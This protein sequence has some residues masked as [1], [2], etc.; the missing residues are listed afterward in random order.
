[1]AW[2]VYVTDQCKEAAKKH[3]VT[4]RVKQFQQEVEQL[5]A[6]SLARF[7]QFPTPYL[8]KK[9]FAVY[10]GR[11]IASRKDLLVDGEEHTVIIFLDYMTRGDDAYEGKSGF[12]HD[13]EGYG[14]KHYNGGDFPEDIL[15][16]YIRT[17][18]EKEPVQEMPRPSNEEL[19]FLYAPLQREDFGGRMIYES[20]EW[21]SAINREEYRGSLR[22][23]SEKIGSSDQK[24]VFVYN[25]CEILQYTFDDLDI[26]FLAGIGTPSKLDE[27]QMEFDQYFND[28]SSV[29][30]L[31]AIAQRSRHAYP[32]LLLADYAL[33]ENIETNNTGNMALSPEEGTLLDDIRKKGDGAYPLFI[34]GRAGSGKSTILQ[35]LFTDYLDFYLRENL[36]RADINPP[37]YLTCNDRLLEKA[38]ESVQQFLLCS[39]TQT[40]DKPYTKAGLNSNPEFV[41]AF[42]PFYVYLKK[43]IPKSEQHLFSPGNHIKYSDFI[44]LW[45]DRYK[46]PIDVTPEVAWHVIRTFIKGNNIE[47]FLTTD[48]YTNSLPR[49]EH[50]VTNENYQFIFDEVW[51]KW[52]KTLTVKSTDEDLPGEYWDDQD[53]VRFVV[54]KNYFSKTYPVVFCDEAQD[55]TRIELNCILNMSLFSHRKTYSHETT[56]IPFAFAGDPFQTLNPTGFRW[57]ATKVSFVE[58][59]INSHSFDNRSAVPDINFRELGNNYR[60]QQNIVGFCNCVQGIRSHVLD[61]K[62]SPQT[63]WFFEKN[64]L[65]AVYYDEMNKSFWE[66]VKKRQDVVFV[67]PCNEGEEEKYW[68]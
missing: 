20:I 57:E 35:Y 33:W 22:S 19:G 12:G 52:Y 25:N 28:K 13:P 10:E 66:W 3:S 61:E 64:A 63:P 2:Y 32:E 1:M 36:S 43:L 24:R 23:I 55:F 30:L 56:K 5:Q 45:K 15:N 6:T 60:S 50:T 7:C 39:S 21:A 42:Q 48:E 34:N 62:F 65:P 58:Q 37:L 26:R 40:S 59:F 67:V 53:L 49:E 51:T 16:D 11:L 9:K 54:R 68:S 18:T 31:N 44:R 38:K 47:D 27:L 14:R 4:Q 29:K 17:R 8:V 46:E 41:N